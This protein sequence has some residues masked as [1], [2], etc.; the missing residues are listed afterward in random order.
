MIQKLERIVWPHV[1]SLLLQRIQ[2]I[3]ESQRETN[4]GVVIVEAA[5]LLDAEWDANELFDA[6]W[7]VRASPDTS[8]ERL[9]Q[10]RGMEREDALKRMKAQLSRRGIE[11]WQEELAKGAVT[12][13][14]E[15]EGAD[16]WDKMKECLVDPG[17]WKDNRCPMLGDEMV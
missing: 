14:I 7:I 11:N 17:C 3:Q 12:A 16:L 15:N 5:V 2:D 13:V 9:V 1:K 6:I 10:K 4:H 8:T